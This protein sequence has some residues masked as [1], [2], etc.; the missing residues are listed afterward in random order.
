M[1]TV[2][3]VVIIVVI[4]ADSGVALIYLEFRT[5]RSGHFQGYQK[6][7]PSSHDSDSYAT[8]VQGVSVQDLNVVVGF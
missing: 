4:T 5:H 1:I 8:Q 6:K 2:V 3:I 7:Q